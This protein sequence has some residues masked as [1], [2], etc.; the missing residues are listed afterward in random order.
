MTMPATQAQ[1]LAEEHL[2]RLS[3]LSAQVDEVTLRRVLYQC[4]L[5]LDAASAE[6]RA[7]LFGMVGHAWFRLRA[8]DKALDAY[9]NASHYEPLSVGYGTSAAACLIELGRLDE[10]LVQLRAARA[11]PDA[12]R[13]DRLVI[14]ANEAEALHKLGATAAAR[15]ALAEAAKV[16]DARDPVDLFVL[17]QQAA[18][19][20]CDDD[21]AEYY[22]RH[23]AA[24]QGVELGEA[25]AV[26]FI[27]D[28]PEALKARMREVAPLAAAIARVTERDASATP[29]PSDLPHLP[30]APDAAD[31]LCALVEGPPEPTD[32]L[33]RLVGRGHA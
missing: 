12:P 19:I 15:A 8:F 22:A 9:R 17:G 16:G 13:H 4:K 14:L 5:T 27:A 32:A 21:A 3:D 28:A 6:D 33:R 25:S 11:K 30:L 26:Q 10:A 23:L 24:V 2:A 18:N 1:K 20:G 29:P 31:A 7:V